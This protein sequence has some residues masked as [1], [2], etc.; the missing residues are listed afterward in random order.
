MVSL[1]TVNPFAVVGAT[2]KVALPLL[3]VAA[4][5]VTLPI[6]NVTVP[7]GVPLFVVTVAVKL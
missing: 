4:P 7:V 2:F 1:P 6:L 5:T 3:K